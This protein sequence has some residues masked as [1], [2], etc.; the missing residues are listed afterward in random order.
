MLDLGAAHAGDAGQLAGGIA[1]GMKK[2]ADDS[3]SVALAGLDAISFQPR[4]VE[5][6]GW[7]AAAGVEVGDQVQS[8]H[9]LILGRST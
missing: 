5:Q 7:G 3:E 6:Q 2:A 9:G 8:V 4:R 1:K